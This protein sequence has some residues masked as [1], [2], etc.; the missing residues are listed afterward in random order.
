VLQ[1]QRGQQVVM[2]PNGQ[3]LMMQPGMMPM[4]G[5]PMQRGVVSCDDPIERP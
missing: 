2:A 3:V 4:Q 1:Q 5:M